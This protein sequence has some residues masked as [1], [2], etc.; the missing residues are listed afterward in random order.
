MVQSA[1]ILLVNSCYFSSDNFAPF[2][3]HNCFPD[4]FCLSHVAW[5]LSDFSFH[6]VSYSN[7]GIKRFSSDL[8]CTPSIALF[9]LGDSGGTSRFLTLSFVW[10]SVHDDYILIIG[11]T[12]P[13]YYLKCNFSLLRACILHLCQWYVGH[14]WGINQPMRAV[15]LIFCTSYFLYW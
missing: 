4:E 12:D 7:I 11:M 5:Y 10:Y 2:R 3:P 1:F 6:I 15:T 14:L 13:L 8:N 9:D